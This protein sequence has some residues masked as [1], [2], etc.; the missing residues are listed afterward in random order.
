MAEAIVQN[1]LDIIIAKQKVLEN[2]VLEI[3]TKVD[4]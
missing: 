4:K 1:K 3:E 2:L